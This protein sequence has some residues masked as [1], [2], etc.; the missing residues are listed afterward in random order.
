MQILGCYIPALHSCATHIQAR[1]VLLFY[2]FATYRQDPWSI[3]T[4]CVC[5]LAL[6]LAWVVWYAFFYFSLEESSTTICYH[7]IAA[8]TLKL[9]STYAAGRNTQDAKVTQCSPTHFCFHKNIT[10]SNKFTF[11]CLCRTLWFGCIHG[12]IHRLF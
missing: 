2:T 9:S 11:P 7:A 5:G 1:W 4:S 8:V 3:H 12:Y 10:C 6:Q